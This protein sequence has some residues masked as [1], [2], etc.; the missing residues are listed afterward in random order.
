[1]DFLVGAGGA[2]ASA[3]VPFL[4][5][6]TFDVYVLQRRSTT[7]AAFEIRA[8]GAARQIFSLTRGLGSLS[9][10]PQN[11]FV[12]LGINGGRRRSHR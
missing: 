1:M 3:G 6:R 2:N 7:S 4:A 12:R 8:G 11:Y 9:G 10:H 5:L